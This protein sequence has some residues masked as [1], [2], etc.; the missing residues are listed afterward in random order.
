MRIPELIFQG[1]LCGKEDSSE[2]VDFSLP[3]VDIFIA[4]IL[5]LLTIN[6]LKSWGIAIK[7]FIQSERW[8][9]H[10]LSLSKSEPAFF[11]V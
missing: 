9:L 4:A 5:I 3:K 10:Y 6:L 2:T 7:N 8:I 11:I 1:L